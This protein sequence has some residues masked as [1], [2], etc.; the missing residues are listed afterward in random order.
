LKREELEDITPKTA[1]DRS[2][3]RIQE[4]KRD[5]PDAYSQ[6]EREIANKGYYSV[7]DMEHKLR[8]YERKCLEDFAEISR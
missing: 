1:Y 7:E 8:K 2:L 4:I 6:L 5:F 3:D